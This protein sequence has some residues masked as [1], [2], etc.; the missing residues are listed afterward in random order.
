MIFLTALMVSTVQVELIITNQLMEQLEMSVLRVTTATV[1]LNLF[2]LWLLIRIELE[3]HLARH[4]LKVTTA[5]TQV[6]K[7]QLFAQ[8]NII[9]KKE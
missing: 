4:A 6:L 7:S 2:V 5:Q 3:L 8:T 9:V 1:E